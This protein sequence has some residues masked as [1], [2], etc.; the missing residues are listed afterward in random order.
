MMPDQWYPLIEAGRVGRK[1]V[2]VT[3]FGEKLVLWRDG[4]GRAVCMRDRC[5][6]R[7]AALSRGKVVA[8]QLECPYHGFR[9]GSDGRCAAMPCEGRD[10][11]IPPGMRAA[12]LPLRER[13]G[14][15]WA[16]RGDGD[17]SAA[18]IAWFDQIDPAHAGTAAV[19]FDWPI[20]FVRTVE[21]NFDIHHTPFV[22]G[23]VLPGLGA[24]LDPYDVEVHGDHIVT[25]GRLRKENSEGVAFRVEY[26]AP[27]LTYFEFG[28][29][30]FVV[31]DCPIDADST[32]RWVAYR[33]DYVRLPALQWLGS[34]LSMQLDWKLIQLRQDLRMIE[35]LTPALPA[36]GLDKL[37]HA[38]AGLAAWRKLY[39]RLAAG[40]G[41]DAALRRVS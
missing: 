4:E 41:S 5:P 22:H 17:A 39:R 12:P 23:N 8:G 26:K 32:W 6:H 1:P 27:S 11:K 3:R 14:L 35:T 24:R 40:D 21:S 38:D 28:K 20:N 33:Q 18:E 36:E 16:F 7:G 19:A 37:V 13:H 29:L 10:A 15:V 34:W 31:A 25:T 30:F 2:G 9:F